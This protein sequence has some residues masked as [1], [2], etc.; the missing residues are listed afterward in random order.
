MAD[1]AVNNVAEQALRFAVEFHQLHLLD[2]EKI[3][4]TGIYLAGPGSIISVEKSL[5]LAACVMTFSRVRLSPHCCKTWT[6]V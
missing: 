1:V 2:R 6:R 4:Q 3:I 5:M